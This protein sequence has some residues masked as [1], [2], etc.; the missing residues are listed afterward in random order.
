MIKFWSIILL[1]GITTACANTGVPS[2]D[3]TA[4]YKPS[5]VNEQFVVPLHAEQQPSTF[6]NPN[7][8]KGS[9]YHLKGIGGE[10]GLYPPLAYFEELSSLG[11]NE[12]EDKRLGHTHFFSNN[13]T[14]ISVV[15]KE[16]FIQIYE[17]KKDA[18]Y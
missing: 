3:A 2:Y 6:S 12:L 1:I 7:I 4:G 15:I 8:L 9:T 18:K 16:D 14:V 13:Q 5:A 11:W 10:Q 17:L